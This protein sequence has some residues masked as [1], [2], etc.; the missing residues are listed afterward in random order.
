MDD[1]E[2]EK[3]Q[4]SIMSDPMIT[5]LGNAS[6][7]ECI[8]DWTSIFHDRLKISVPFEIDIDLTAVGRRG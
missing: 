4:N 6:D 7:P 8:S 1:E 2:I 5:R 3:R